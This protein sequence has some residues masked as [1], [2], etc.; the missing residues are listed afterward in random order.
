MM[1]NNGLL[2][3][4]DVIQIGGRNATICFITKYNNENYICVAFDGEKIEYNIYKYI[5]NNDKLLVSKDISQDDMKEVLRIFM[6]QGLD[7][8][9]IPKGFEQVFQAII[10]SNQ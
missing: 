10:E 9:G 3:V 8:Y 4:G 5:F 6:E 1:N 7:E 2:E